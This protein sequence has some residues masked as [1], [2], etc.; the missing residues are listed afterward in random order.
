LNNILQPVEIHNITDQDG[1]S[2]ADALGYTNNSLFSYV[3]KSYRQHNTIK[4]QDDNTDLNEINN[5]DLALYNSS[6]NEIGPYYSIDSA[7]EYNIVYVF[8]Y[9][10]LTNT[11]SSN[12]TYSITFGEDHTNV[13]LLIVGG[14]GGGGSGLDLYGAGGGGTGGILHNT[15]ITLHKNVEYQIIVGN[16]GDGNTNG[17]D[18]MFYLDDENY[19]LA[20]GGGKGGSHNSAPGSGGGGSGNPDYKMVV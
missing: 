12:T 6:C 13:D 2:L 1:G 20:K 5:I 4:I 14:G 18:S 10:E 7:N 17:Y 3:P 19:A 9:D 8:K 11:D 16:G 15:N